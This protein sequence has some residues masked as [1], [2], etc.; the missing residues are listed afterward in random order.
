MLSPFIPSVQVGIN[1]FMAKDQRHGVA[2][3][4]A[5][6]GG[7]VPQGFMVDKPERL[8]NPTQTVID[9][10]FKQITRM[11]M[12]PAHLEIILNNRRRV[13]K[14]GERRPILVQTLN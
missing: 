11:G 5:E 1:P 3:V 14:Y 7:V 8:L 10:M 9:D 13:Y 6:D 4:E 12:Q 2:W